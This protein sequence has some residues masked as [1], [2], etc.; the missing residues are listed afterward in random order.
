MRTSATLSDDVGQALKEYSKAH[1]RS[2]AYFVRV[3]LRHFLEAKGY[4][5]KP[6]RE[7]RGGFRVPKGYVKEQP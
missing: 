1:N 4:K 3:A 5:F 6:D 7:M 2:E